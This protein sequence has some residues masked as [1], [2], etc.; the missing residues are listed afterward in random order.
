MADPWEA[1]VRRAF[2]QLGFQ[3]EN[4]RVAMVKFTEDVKELLISFTVLSHEAARQFAIQSMGIAESDIR[5]V[6]LYCPKRGSHVWLWNH[7]RIPFP[8]D[9]SKHGD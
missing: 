8:P 2:E 5:A 4:L 9:W 3:V 1:V 6:V 7:R